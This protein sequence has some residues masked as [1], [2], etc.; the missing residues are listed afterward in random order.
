MKKLLLM[1][2]AF[3]LVACGGDG[4][5]SPSNNPVGS[6]SLSQVNG[7]ALPQT[8]FQNSV[9]YVEVVSGTLVLRQDGS[10]TETRNNRAVYIT[11]GTQSSSVVENGT[12][13]ITGTQVTFTIPASG[14]Q[15]ALSYTGAIS[16]GAV[17][18]T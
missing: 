11:G 10:Y 17:T 2:S 7:A 6:Y 16:G 14:G 5:T 18:Y 1:V 15:S 9:G 3:L 8:Y 4:P 13:S 12:Y